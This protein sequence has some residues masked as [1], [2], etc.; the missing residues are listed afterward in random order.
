[1]MDSP[2]R[3]CGCS[4]ASVTPAQ[5]ERAQRPI[6]T[7]CDTVD[8]TGIVDI[9]ELLSLQAHRRTLVSPPTESK[10]SGC[11]PTV[12]NRPRWTFDRA[13]SVDDHVGEPSE[14][15]W[16]AVHQ[17]S[18]MTCNRSQAEPACGNAEF[19]YDIPMDARTL[20][21]IG[22]MR[23]EVCFD[24]E[25]QDDCLMDRDTP[26]R[27]RRPRRLK[28]V[29]DLQLKCGGT[30]EGAGPR[31]PAWTRGQPP[32]ADGHSTADTHETEGMPPAHGRPSPVLV[33]EGKYKAGWAYRVSKWD[34]KQILEDRFEKAYQVVRS[35]ELELLGYLQYW[36]DETKLRSLWTARHQ[37]RVA[38]LDFWFGSFKA[39]WFR[40]RLLTVAHT[41]ANWSACFEHG[42]YGF[43][44]PV[45]I[46][47]Y[48]NS[49]S[50]AGFHAEPNVVTLCRPW[51]DI[52][53]KYG[54]FERVEAEQV[55][56]VIHEMGHYS[57]AGGVPYTPNFVI[58]A[59]SGLLAAPRDRRNDVCGG[60][61]CYQ[62]SIFSNGLY[63]GG[64]PHE[65]VEEFEQGNN[66]AGH[67]MLDNIDNYAS[68]MWNRWQDRNYGV[69]K[70]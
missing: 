4:D 30:S 34:D 20:G 55:F 41:L 15:P 26:P 47:L 17:H 24:D 28:V 31:A 27:L 51:F 22:G 42:F 65:L 9:S 6:A 62:G 44:K 1:M 52:E 50:N 67:D 32:Q 69:F 39:R 21:S 7:S 48:T 33:Y 58:G 56:T 64:R 38:A 59:W 3:P 68:Y 36:D 25:A 2:T 46:R 19:E 35:A 8:R 45:L 29:D 66:D 18:Q 37:H 12:Q 11:V 40:T 23:H 14:V 63:N 43:H 5:P 61:R 53:K 70:F 60:G 49:G 16:T 10:G 57:G 54:E 13:Y